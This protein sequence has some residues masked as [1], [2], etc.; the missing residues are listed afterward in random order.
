[1][2]L[3]V[4]EDPDAVRRQSPCCPLPC[5]VCGHP[6]TAKGCAWWQYG[7]CVPGQGCVGLAC[8]TVPPP[9]Q[10]FDS[11]A[12]D[13]PLVP[14]SGPEGV[15][16]STERGV[17]L[18]AEDGLTAALGRPERR[19]GDLVRQLSASFQHG[20]AVFSLF[21]RLRP[22]LEAGVPCLPAGTWALLNRM[23]TCLFC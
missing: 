14:S 9:R 2:L 21:P 11:E 1:M 12:L 17:L 7:R 16:H 22:L 23:T 19:R 20:P 10:H 5:S 18:P 13:G 8:W 3:R 6:G 4:P 15:G